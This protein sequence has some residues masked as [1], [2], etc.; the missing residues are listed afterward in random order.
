MATGQGRST[1][2]VSVIYV[3]HRDSSTSDNRGKWH[4]GMLKQMKKKR[5]KER[6]CFELKWIIKYVIGI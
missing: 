4:K 5:K 2:C 1:S 6:G 3:V